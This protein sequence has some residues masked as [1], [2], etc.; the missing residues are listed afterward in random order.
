MVISFDE[1]GFTLK[2]PFSHNLILILFLK[3]DTEKFNFSPHKI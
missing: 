3:V 1:T 2:S